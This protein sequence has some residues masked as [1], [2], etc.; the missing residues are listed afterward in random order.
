[1]RIE[2][3]LTWWPIAETNVREF[4]IVN[5]ENAFSKVFAKNGLV[6]ENTQVFVHRITCKGKKVVDRK[7]FYPFVTLDNTNKGFYVYEGAIITLEFK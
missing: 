5:Q 4:E 3:F 6:N 7:V 1:M 2:F